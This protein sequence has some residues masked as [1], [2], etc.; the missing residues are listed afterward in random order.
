MWIE[1]ALNLRPDL[2]TQPENLDNYDVIYVGYP[3]WWFNVPMA[4]GS[5][6]ESYDLTGK[7]V[8]LFCTSI[9]NGIDVSM[10]YIREVSE[11]ANVLEGYRVHNSSLEDVSA[12]LER[13]G[14]LEEKDGYDDT[15]ISQTE[16]IISPK[17][18][19]LG[20]V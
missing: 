5:F 7:T 6:L 15:E 12:W 10:D 3:I 11:G 16:L 19:S 9:D 13:I 18:S 20:Y 8:V 4:I 2:A 17:E 14:M 1:N